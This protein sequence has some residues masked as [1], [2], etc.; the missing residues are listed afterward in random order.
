MRIW[1]ESGRTRPR[2][3]VD[4]RRPEIFLSQ[5]NRGKDAP[6]FPHGGKAE[7]GC[8]WRGAPGLNASLPQS[9]R[10]HQAARRAA[11]RWGVPADAVRQGDVWRGLP[12][13]R[14]KNKQH[15]SRRGAV[16][17]LVARAHQKVEPGPSVSTIHLLQR[18][19]P[20]VDPTYRWDVR[21]SRTVSGFRKQ[22]QVQQDALTQT[23]N[24]N[25]PFSRPRGVYHL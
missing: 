6:P 2:R 4:L 5:D 23:S 3:G 9:G 11:A 22:C 18:L 1:R 7:T 14:Q 8:R 13:V 16:G 12:P 25:A 24:G 19:A 20:S 21:F 10:M 15:L 17:T